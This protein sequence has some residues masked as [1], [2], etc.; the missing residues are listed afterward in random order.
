MDKYRYE[1]CAPVYLLLLYLGCTYNKHAEV[2]C[3]SARVPVIEQMQVQ[4]GGKPMLFLDSRCTMRM[5]ANKSNKG[6]I[7][8]SRR[9]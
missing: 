3:L 7:S 1:S 4:H 6:N 9:R 2:A 8:V 5:H